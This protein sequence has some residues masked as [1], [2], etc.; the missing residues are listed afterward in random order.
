[1]NFCFMKSIE[2]NLFHANVPFLF[3]MKLSEKNLGFLIFFSGGIEMDIRVKW[4]NGTLGTSLPVRKV[5]N[6][7]CNQVTDFTLN[8]Y[9]F[10]FAKQKNNKKKIHFYN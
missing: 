10:F 2:F 3:P 5:D 8:S 6:Q 4:V 9:L 1:M 7:K